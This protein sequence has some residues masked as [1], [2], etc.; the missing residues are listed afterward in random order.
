M[1]LREGNRTATWLKGT[2][3]MGR[4]ESALLKI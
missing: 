1:E 3:L 4:M 2:T